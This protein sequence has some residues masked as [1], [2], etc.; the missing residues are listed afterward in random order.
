MTRHFKSPTYLPTAEEV[1]FSSARWEV[2]TL[3][4]HYRSTKV[5]QGQTNTP[6]PC[7][8]QKEKSEWI[9][10]YSTVHPQDQLRKE[11]ELKGNKAMK[12]PKEVPTST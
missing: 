11:N 10:K 6:H 8:Q 2:V 4:L 9:P 12:T 3:L 5:D 1:S 7:I